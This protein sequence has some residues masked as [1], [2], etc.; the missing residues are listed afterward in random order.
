MSNWIRPPMFLA[1]AVTAV[2]LAP[3]AQAAP[4]APTCTSAGATSTLC[5]SAGNAQLVATPPEVDYQAQYPFFGTY[6]LLFHH[7]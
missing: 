7:G 6:G 5:Q 1:A 2:A 4:T 3:V